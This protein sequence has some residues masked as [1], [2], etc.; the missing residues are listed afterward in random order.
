MHARPARGLVTER[1]ALGI[2]WATIGLGLLHVLATPA[3]VPEL[4]APAMWLASGGG[5]FAM[6]GVLNLLRVRHVETAPELRP[7]CLLANVITT[8]FTVGLAVVMGAT[9]THEPQVLV[10]VALAGG[11]TLLTLTGAPRPAGG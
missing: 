11:A 10:A 5:A 1:L 7:T 6:V 2:G 3:Y 4:G 9:L 8:A